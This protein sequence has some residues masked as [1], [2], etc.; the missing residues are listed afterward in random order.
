MT[1][2]DVYRSDI[3]PAPAARV[4]SVIRDFNALPTWTP[5]VADSRIEGGMPPDR[6]GCVR[7]FRLRD[8]GTIRESLLM[9]DDANM[10]CSYSI[11]DS[12]MNVKNYRATLRLNPV[13]RENQCFAEWEASFEC[14]P[15]EEAGLVRQIGDGVFA[16]GLRHL[17]ARFGERP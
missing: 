10:A 17:R 16:S 12:P 1:M 6:L 9:L 13:V 4:W 11:L 8:G 14:P 5:F 3:I 2:A 15:M 7:N